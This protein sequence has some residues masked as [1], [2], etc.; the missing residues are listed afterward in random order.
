M[1]SEQQE[2]AWRGGWRPAGYTEPSD[3]DIAFSAQYPG[4]V[5]ANW[6]H[7]DYADFVRRR[8]ESR[9]QDRNLLTEKR[10]KK[11]ARRS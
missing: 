9:I 7:P 8:E 11:D 5:Q 1:N 2:E 6:A 3:D 10:T 4:W